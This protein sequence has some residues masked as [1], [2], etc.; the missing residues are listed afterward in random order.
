MRKRQ[1]SSPSD[2]KDVRSDR[3]PLV[4]GSSACIQFASQPQ[5]TVVTGRA[6]WR[7]KKSR[8]KQRLTRI[9]KVSESGR[10]NSM[11]EIRAVHRQVFAADRIDRIERRIVFDQ[12]FD[13]DFERSLQDGAH[14]SLGI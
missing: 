7:S 12:R 13:A 9:S 6:F 3:S 10:L 14:D 2:S 1:A 5:S 11:G 8:K 4:A